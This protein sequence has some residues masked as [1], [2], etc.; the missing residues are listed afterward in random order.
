MVKEE[1]AGRY[2][3]CDPRTMCKAVTGRQHLRATIT[4][5]NFPRYGHYLTFISPLDLT[6]AY[7]EVAQRISAPSPFPTPCKHL[8]LLLL[9]LKSHWN[10]KPVTLRLYFPITFIRVSTNHSNSKIFQVNRKNANAKQTAV[11]RQII[12]RLL[13][14]RGKAMFTSGI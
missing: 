12:L 9:C 10:L 2:Y 7:S 1:G 11:S 4:E 13:P 14:Y 8:L 6:L 3:N 5:A